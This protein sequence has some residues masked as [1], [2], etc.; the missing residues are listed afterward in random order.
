MLRHTCLREHQLLFNLFV[1][2][3]SSF[4]PLSVLHLLADLVAEDLVP[5][6]LHA[7]DWQLSA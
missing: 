2:T 4:C 5:V 7:G 3:L 1:I 6:D